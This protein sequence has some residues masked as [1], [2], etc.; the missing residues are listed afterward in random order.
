MSEI[1]YVMSVRAVK[2]GAFVADVGSTRFLRVPVTAAVPSPDQAS[3]PASRWYA[4]VQAAGAWKND[5]G[6]DRGDILILIHGFNNS[7]A[8][9]LDRHRRIKKGLAALN[10]KGVVVSF[11]WPSDNNALAYLPDRHRAKETALQLVT[12]GVRYLSATQRP[13]C[14]INV[15]LLG[16]S[17]GAYVIREAFD[18]ADDTQLKNSAWTVSQMMLIA[19]DISSASLSADD[20][21]AKS[22]YNHCVRLTNYS[23]SHDDVLDLSNVKRVGLAPRVGRRGLPSDAPAKAVN[24]DCSEYYAL[25][26][27]DTTVER[28]DQPDRRTGAP[29]HSWF[30][31]NATFTRDLFN[32]IIGVDRQSSPTR[33]IGSDGLLHLQR[34]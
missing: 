13:D 5:N 29:S 24:V 23:N 28:T 4:E 34:P 25:L 22:M 16:H 32:T 26:D 18:D 6:E 2:Q 14:P 31:G 17:T 12:D 19:G 27:A 33:V 20:S 1:D 21:G 8:D 11:D 30:F 9:V 15:H 3:G 10:F 7:E